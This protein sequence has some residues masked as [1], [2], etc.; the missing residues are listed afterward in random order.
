VRTLLLSWFIGIPLRLWKYCY[1]YMK[2]T[3]C[4]GHL[5]TFRTTIELFCSSC[6]LSNR[7]YL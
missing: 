7:F 3:H 5:F 4:Y 2:Y 6:R 1:Q